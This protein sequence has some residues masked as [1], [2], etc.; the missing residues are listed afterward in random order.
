MEG[1]DG[2]SNPSN[3]EVHCIGYCTAGWGVGKASRPKCCVWVFEN[4]SK[5]KYIIDVFG[6]RDTAEPL[7]PI[8]RVV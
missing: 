6:W 1:D 7:A 4:V 3:R 2:T 5:Y 8:V